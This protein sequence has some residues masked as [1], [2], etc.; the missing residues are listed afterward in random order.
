MGVLTAGAEKF[1][2][3][4]DLTMINGYDTAGIAGYYL[5]GSGYTQ[6]TVTQIN[7][8]GKKLHWSIKNV[9]GA[10]TGSI[11]LHVNVLYIKSTLIRD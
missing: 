7:I 1:A 6:C 4:A 9:G 11:T 3:T 10:Q 8:D 2:Q 5:A